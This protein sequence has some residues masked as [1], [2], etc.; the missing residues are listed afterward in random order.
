MNTQITYIC[1]K[2]YSSAFDLSLFVDFELDVSNY[3]VDSHSLFCTDVLI[4]Q[5]SHHHDCLNEI[6]KIHNTFQHKPIIIIFDYFDTRCI[7]WAISQ[8][9]NNIIVL[10]DEMITLKNMINK[11][12]DQPYSYNID[13]IKESETKCK[14]SSLTLDFEHKTINAVNLIHKNYS[15][16]ILMA[17]AASLCNM[18]IST[19]TRAFKNEQ[20]VTFC[21]YLNLLRLCSAKKFLR[22]TKLPVSQIAYLCGFN[23]AAYFTRL[24]KS[25]ENKTPKQ[26]RG[27]SQ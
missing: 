24:F 9:I 1:E 27:L 6:E 25:I 4:F 12:I 11:L 14:Y 15:T 17:E 13:N 10:P 22:N 20:G 5:Y 8:K 3:P 19:F 2:D 26:Y 23:D 21:Q 7:S 18:S 16:K